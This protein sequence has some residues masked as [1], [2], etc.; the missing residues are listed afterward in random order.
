[1]SFLQKLILDSGGQ[2][3]FMAMGAGI[4]NTALFVAGK[5]SETGYINLTMGTVAA[6]IAMKTWEQITS[7]KTPNEAKDPY[8]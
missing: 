5:L 3:F 8:A 6:F 4:V 1:M 7:I 2:R